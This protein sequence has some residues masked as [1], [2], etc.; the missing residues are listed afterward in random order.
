M[1]VA[2]MRVHAVRDGAAGSMQPWSVYTS[3]V[4]R[5]EELLEIM[6]QLR[7]P[8]RGCPWD[9]EQTFETIAPYTIEEAYEVE[10][11]IRRADWSALPGELG[12]LL[13]QVVFHAQLA[14]E[15]GEFGFDEVVEAICR[16]L[17]RRHPH[18]F[19]ADVVRSAEEQTERWEGMK[20]EER[21]AQADGS[22]GALDGIPVG[23]PA[24]M[25]S[26]KLQ[27]RARRVGFR[28]PGVAESL[29]KLEEEL[30]EL[31]EAAMGSDPAHVL[32]ELGDVLFASVSVALELGVDPET[33]MRAANTKFELR[34]RQM[35]EAL[36]ARGEDFSSKSLGQLLELW[37]EAKRDDG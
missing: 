29:S 13:L 23:L 22:V 37:R 9:L 17:V 25:R 10:D 4:A 31:R 34:F 1:A 30:A 27:Q 18:V 14:S 28:W 11:A 16:K 8:E 20:A 36:A 21:A 12:D 5:I 7:D 26:D 33:A 15:A 32:D 2:R 19:A 6:A 35:E 24:L 3:R